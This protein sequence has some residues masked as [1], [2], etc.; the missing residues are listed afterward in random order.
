MIEGLSVILKQQNPHPP[1]EGEAAADQ[2]ESTLGS[3]QPADKCIL[4]EL[5]GDP[6]NS[7]NLF[8][9]Y[10]PTPAPSARN[11]HVLDGIGWHEIAKISLTNT[12]VPSLQQILPSYLGGRYVAEQ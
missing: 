1:L 3:E 4:G 6:L 10:A 5:E 8:P 9:I 11:L 2:A 7:S 12:K